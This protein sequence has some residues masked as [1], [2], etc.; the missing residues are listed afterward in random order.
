MRFKG[1]MREW[2]NIFKVQKIKLHKSLLD[3]KIH[4]YHQ[5]LKFT[6]NAI[7]NKLKKKTKLTLKQ[8]KTEYSPELVGIGRNRPEFGMKWNEDV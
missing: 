3:F 8:S 1:K 4:R 7:K 2:G 6:K 5:D